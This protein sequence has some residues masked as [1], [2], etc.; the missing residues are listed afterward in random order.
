VDRF[1]TAP[2][3]LAALLV[4]AATTGCGGP[5]AH[6]RDAAGGDDHEVVYDSATFQLARGERIQIIFFRRT[7]APIG[8]ADPDFEYVLLELPERRKYGWVRE[9]GV[10]VYR[11]VRVAGRDQLWR[12]V[13]GLADMRLSNEKRKLALEADVTM[14]PLRGEGTE[15]HVWSADLK[16]PEDMARTQGL[17]N[18]Y[19]EWLLSLVKPDE[20][21]EGAAE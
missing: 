6:V 14:E 7:A 18:R 5:S 15:V 1:R 9:D 12:G 11:W 3:A 17:V 16:C 10:P 21:T 2:T 20:A 8:E 19:A 13:S 4:A